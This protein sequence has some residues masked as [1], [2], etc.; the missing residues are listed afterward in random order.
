MDEFEAFEVKPFV[1]SLLGMGDW[2]EFMDK[3]YEVPELP[4]NLPERKSTDLHLRFS[5]HHCS[6]CL[7]LTDT[8]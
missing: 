5:L 3:V 4:Q 8:L 7:T 1:S 2:S 6:T